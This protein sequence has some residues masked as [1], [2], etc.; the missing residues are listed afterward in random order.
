VFLGSGPEFPAHPVSRRSQRRLD[1]PPD[2]RARRSEKTPV[3]HRGFDVQDRFTLLEFHVDTLLGF[4]ALL[5]GLRGNQEY[6]LSDECHLTDG[7]AKLILH[8]RSHLILARD[9]RR[10]KDGMD[11]LHMAGRPDIR[12]LNARVRVRTVHDLSDE[13]SSGQGDVIDVH[14]FSGHMQSRTLVRRFKGHGQRSVL[15]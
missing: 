7:K 8:H 14:R 12:R 2:H 9:I 1:I 3:G 4:T 10:R 5:F 11:A 13:R 15:R 6:G